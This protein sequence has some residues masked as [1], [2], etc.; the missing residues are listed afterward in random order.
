VPGEPFGNDAETDEYL[1]RLSMQQEDFRTFLAALQRRPT[2]DGAV[3]LEF[4]DH[5]PVVTRPLIK[6]AEGLDAFTNWSSIAYR[7]YYRIHPINTK[8]LAPLPDVDLLN[9]TY[10]GPTLLQ[11]AGLPM[12]DVYAGLLALRD[13]CAGAMYLCPKRERVQRHFS[14]LV[15]GKLLFLDHSKPAIGA[16]SA[17]A[18][19]A[20]HGRGNSPLPK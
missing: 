7:T 12:D 18:A 2:K 10:L 1:R 20:D 14:R 15:E 13:E 8:L 16:G 5:H 3:L 19:P 17:A 9:I 4:G 11:V 6:A